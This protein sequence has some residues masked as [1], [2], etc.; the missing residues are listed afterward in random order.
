MAEPDFSGVFETENAKSGET[1]QEPT[2]P[3]EDEKNGATGGEMPEGEEVREV[4]DPEKQHTKNE[5]TKDVQTKEENAKYAAARRK[6]ERE[7]DRMIEKVRNETRVEAEKE[8]DQLIAA[9]HMVNPYTKAPICSK[10]DFL[11]WQKT[12]EKES[13]DSLKG[14]LQQAGIDESEIERFIENHPAVKEAKSSLEKL[15]ADKDKA[16]TDR[17]KTTVDQEL[18]KIREWDGSVKNLTDITNAENYETIY[19]K[20]KRGYTLSDAFYLANLDHMNRQTVS[21]AEQSVL[22]HVLSKEHLAGTKMRGVGDVSV[23]QE[24]MREFKRL[25]PNAS[26]DEIRLFYQK[27]LAHLKK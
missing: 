17:I 15:R 20:V 7:R 2:A 22:N 3:V 18:A 4:T 21:K 6:A 26:A 5:N 9:S 12:Y 16:E 14:K 27:D 13:T 11:A 1:A 19:E 25:M 8:M 23:P 24:V 10:A